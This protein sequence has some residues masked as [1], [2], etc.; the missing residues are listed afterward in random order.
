MLLRWFGCCMVAGWRLMIM[1]SNNIPPCMQSLDHDGQLSYFERHSF[2]HKHICSSISA[3]IDIPLCRVHGDR[4]LQGKSKCKWRE[5]WYL[6]R[7]PG[8][9]LH[10]WQGVIGVSMGSGCGHL[11]PKACVDIVPLDF[12]SVLTNVWTI[13]DIWLCLGNPILA[14]VLQ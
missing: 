9:L 1:A 4:H 8:K 3:D 2:M 12:S 14:W 7:S 6:C 11:W 10:A 5:R 13:Q